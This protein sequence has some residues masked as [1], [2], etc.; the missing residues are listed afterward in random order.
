MG[1]CSN[2]IG[3]DYPLSPACYVAP[4]STAA[5]T[6]LQQSR[7][8]LKAIRRFL[9]ASTITRRVWRCEIIMFRALMENFTAFPLKTAVARNCLLSHGS[10]AF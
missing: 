8:T 1:L 3:C 6:R 10:P 5:T 4:F 9:K 7:S 2:P